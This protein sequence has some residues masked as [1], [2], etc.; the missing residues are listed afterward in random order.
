MNIS[1]KYKVTIFEYKVNL[2]EFGF[3]NSAY[4]NCT[5]LPNDN[6]VF[7]HSD[8]TDKIFQILIWC[9]R[10]LNNGGIYA[11]VVV[12]ML[13]LNEFTFARLSVIQTYTYDFDGSRV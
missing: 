11:P 1:F 9:A 10:H 4:C 5:W 12:K 3:S 7:L 6:S 8:I 2:F 13:I